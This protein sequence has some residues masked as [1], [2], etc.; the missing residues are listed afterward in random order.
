[1]KR[2]AGAA[3]ERGKKLRLQVLSTV[4][5]VFVTFLLRAV[6]AVMFS[7]S[8]ALQ[9]DDNGCPGFCD[10]PCHDVHTLVQ[11]WIAF[12]PEF[13]FTVTLISSPLA[14]LIALWGVTTQR[15]LQLMSSSAREMSSKHPG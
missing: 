14:L 10:V 6:F 9:H 3:S 15:T 11:S 1:M 8:G 13:Q 7:V 12:T 2:L 4:S 5:V